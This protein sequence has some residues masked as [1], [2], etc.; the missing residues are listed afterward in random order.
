MSSEEEHEEGTKSPDEEN[1]LNST[2]IL[3]EP[4]EN[5]QLRHFSD[6]ELRKCFFFEKYRIKIW[7]YS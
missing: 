6:F 1:G 4:D 2:Q 5:T 7:V 3:N